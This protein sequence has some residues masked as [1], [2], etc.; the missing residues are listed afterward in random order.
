MRSSFSESKLNLDLEKYNIDSN[1]LSK[2]DLN[3]QRIIDGSEDIVTTPIIK[4]ISVD[5]LIA[6]W[7]KVFNANKDLM[8]DVLV[9]MEEKQ[10]GKI[11][12][13]SRAKPWSENKS[14]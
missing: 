1:A 5:E 3:N 13:R 12:A 2:L 10:K 4:R 7:T 9:D 8:N 6:D 14:T 11:S